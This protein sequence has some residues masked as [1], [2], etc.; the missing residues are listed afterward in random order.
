MIVQQF[1]YSYLA[2]EERYKDNE[3][4]IKEGAK[5]DWVYVLLEGQAKVKK[6]SPK[7]LVTIATL[8]QGDIFGEMVLWRAGK[9]ARTASIVA[10]GEIKV[11]ILDTERLLQDYATI[12][13]CLKS[14]MKSLIKRLQETTQKAVDITVGS[15]S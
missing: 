7:G 6:S 10:S 5:G 12:A 9:G 13:P 4:I 2:K 15:A 3:F 14:L 11:G 8:N 1:V